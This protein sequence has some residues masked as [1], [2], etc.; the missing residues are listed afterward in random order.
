MEWFTGTMI[1]VDSTRQNHI[2]EAHLKKTLVLAAAAA[3]LL[4]FACSI[5][6][7]D[8]V[9]TR[10]CGGT[11]NDYAYS[12][13]QTAHCGIKISGLTNSLG[14]GE[15]ISTKPSGASG[16]NGPAII[17]EGKAEMVES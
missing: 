15:W 3:F 11:N 13:R 12:A 7:E 8:A 6:A 16:L 2:G 14:A 1:A 9:W 10:T 4:T 5:F 17:T